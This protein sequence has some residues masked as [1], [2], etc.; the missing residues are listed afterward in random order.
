VAGEEDGV[1]GEL[2]REELAFGL[3]EVLGP[4][5]SCPEGRFASVT[6]LAGSP[7]LLFTVLPFAAVPT[8]RVVRADPFV[9]TDVTEGDVVLSVDVDCAGVVDF[10]VG[11][12]SVPLPL[13]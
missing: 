1:L 11:L 4:P 5:G 2:I 9:L 6:F 10:A 8:V 12:G 3:I 7:D 13:R